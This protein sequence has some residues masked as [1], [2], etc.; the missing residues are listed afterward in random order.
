MRKSEIRLIIEKEC[1]HYAGLHPA[2]QRRFIRK[3]CVLL[4]SK[5]IHF[6]FETNETNNLKI[7]AAAAFTLFSLRSEDKI[8][9][10]F[11]SFTLLKTDAPFQLMDILKRKSIPIR[12]HEDNFWQY[13]VHDIAYAI[14][15]FYLNTEKTLLNF[16]QNIGRAEMLLIDRTEFS[17]T[18][19]TGCIPLSIEDPISSFASIAEMYLLRPS[20]LLIQDEELYSAFSILIKHPDSKN[21]VITRPTHENS[22]ANK[23]NTTNNLHPIYYLTLFSM[24]I[25]TYLIL[26]FVEKTIIPS[27]HVLIALLLFSLTGIYFRRIFQKR[28]IPIIKG[29]YILFSIFGLGVTICLFLLSLNFIFLI[30][31]RKTTQY[32]LKD[33]HQ[34]EVRVDPESQMMHIIVSVKFSN[35][36]SRN[37]S[38]RTNYSHIP[39]RFVVVCQRGLLGY[40]IITDAYFIK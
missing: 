30:G 40:D 33:M 32:K 1:P 26:W 21:Q 14:Y 17:Q 10:L 8:D 15:F 28:N 13:A 35:A 9:S 16:A 6:T 12:I 3:V 27:G 38:L 7:L 23:K 4:R 2:T 36:V 20:Q 5:T 24:F 37:I 34:R 19:L 39:K 11:R 31:E 22:E 18:N 25:G 29:V